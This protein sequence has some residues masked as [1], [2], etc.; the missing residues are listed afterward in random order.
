MA[1]F[2]FDLGPAEAL[3]GSCVVSRLQGLAPGR[4]VTPAA[5]GSCDPQ[6]PVRLGSPAPGTGR[7]GLAG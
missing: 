5:H 2:V 1:E 3:D 7:C 4:V 6:R